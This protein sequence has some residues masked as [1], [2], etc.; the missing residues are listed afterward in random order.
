M[1]PAL[2]TLLVLIG[3]TPVCL[4]QTGGHTQE[5]GRRN[6]DVEQVAEH[7]PYTSAADVMI[8]RKLYLRRCAQCHGAS[9]EGGRGVNLGTGQ[10]RLGGSD[11]ALFLTLRN[12][13][14]D[15]DMPGSRSNA[16]D[17][18]RLVAAVKGLVTA[19]ALESE[20]TTGDSAAGRAV[21]QKSGCAQC[22]IVK[23]E[24]GDLGP[25]LT[26]IGRQRSRKYLQ[27]SIVDPSA[28]VPLQFRTDTI[29]TI[30]GRKMRGIHL[31]ED[32]YSLQL[33]L[34]NGNPRSFLKSELKELTHDKDSF[35]PSYRS[36][37]TVEL[38]DLIAYL[39]SMH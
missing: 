8:G 9:G 20:K 27:S 24:G 26:D 32:D 14:P 18:W 3:R 5:A 19:G 33:R 35:M 12:G 13:V 15:S 11:R 16:I 10:Y 37:S 17:L 2:L 6:V 30:E 25:E 22:H 21:Y 34:L 31:N 7:N 36:F 23:G 4:T 38:D 39:K 1:R 28:D 29:T